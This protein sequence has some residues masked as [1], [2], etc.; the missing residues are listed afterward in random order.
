MSCVILIPIKDHA[1]AKSRM[2]PFLTAQERPLV[3]KAMLEDM[4][5][6]LLPLAF[7]V[8]VT[9]N[10]RQ[11]AAR[12]AK[13][14]WR[15][16]LEEKQISESASVDAASR[17]LAD[18]GAQAVLRLPA[19]LPLIQTGD[20]AELCL[21]TT[22]A[23]CAT[24]APSWDGTGTNALLRTPPGLFPS[25]FG[26]GSFTLHAEEARRVAAHLRVVQNPRLA[27]DLDDFTDIARFLSSPS[28]CETYRTLMD[29]NIKERLPRHALP[30]DPRPGT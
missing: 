26:P 22:P 3:A 29:L 10:S 20:V 30:C 4:I 17:R 2:G 11:I 15:L 28:E 24:M 21:E 9:T 13:L 5:R 1:L 8:A 18:E 16:L 25:H 14:G 12:I 7:P 19:D 23:P 6:A 27:L